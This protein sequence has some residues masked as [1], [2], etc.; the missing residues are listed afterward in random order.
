[1][2]RSFAVT[3][4][5]RLLVAAVAACRDREEPKINVDQISNVM[6]GRTCT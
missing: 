1:M 4:L 5:V 6:N 2:K 3:V